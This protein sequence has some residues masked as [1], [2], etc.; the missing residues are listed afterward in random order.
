MATVAMTQC[1]HRIASG[2]ELIAVR[3]GYRWIAGI[4][5]GKALAVAERVTIGGR[6]GGFDGIEYQNGNHIVVGGKAGERLLGL[7]R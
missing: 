4:Q 7:L 2:C 3:L 5:D 6:R 1:T